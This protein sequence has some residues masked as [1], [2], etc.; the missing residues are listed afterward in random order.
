MLLLVLLLL[1][2]CGGLDPTV[3]PT[4]A[5]IT[6]TVRFRG[7]WPPVDS[8]QD[9]RVVA[10]QNYPPQDVLGEVLSG[11]A[12]FTTE[13]LPFC[14]DSAAYQLR[15]EKLPVTFRYIVV[16][17]QYGPDLLRHWRVVGIYGCPPPADTACQPGSLQVQEAGRW[18][19]ADIE[20]D[21]EHLPPQPFP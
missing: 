8:L 21:F 15:V 2:G 20:V 5:Y 4:E 10:F 18:Y 11:K 1:A 7:A 9:L 17:Q 19:R 14:V 16:A 3:L 13:R 12:L 6:G